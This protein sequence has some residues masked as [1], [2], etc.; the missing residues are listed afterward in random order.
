MSAALRPWVILV[1]GDPSKRS[2]KSPANAV[3][4]PDAMLR[5]ALSLTS[6]GKVCC[7]IADSFR[8]E[9]A[10]VFNTLL[11]SNRHSLGAEEPV[12]HGLERCLA[13]IEIQDP[14]ANVIV[15][16]Y[17]HCAV[18]EVSWLDSTKGAVRLGSR[19]R[20]TV[21]LL[22]DN[23]D[24]DPRV[25]LQKP[26]VCT[27][28]VMVGAST[29]LLALCIGKRATEIVDLVAEAADD[30]RQSTAEGADNAGSPLKVV[31]FRLM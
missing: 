22:H 30:A 13:A 21:Y 28:S 9:W 23:P 24:N 8:R 16:P 19:N 18:E 11:S 5:R 4:E 27:S 10:S 12:L 6:V 20:N 25:A 3:E 1:I 26:E 7:V 15:V 17:N 29:A 31:H 2:Q 14:R